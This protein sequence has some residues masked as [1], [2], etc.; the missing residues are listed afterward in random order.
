MHKVG[1]SSYNTLIYIYTYL[2]Y[3]CANIYQRVS[4]LS[5]HYNYVDYFKKYTITWW[6]DCITERLPHAFLL[7][8]AGTA[9]YSN[10]VESKLI[11]GEL[12]TFVCFRSHI[13]HIMVSV[14]L[15]SVN[16]RLIKLTPAWITFSTLFTIEGLGMSLDSIYVFVYLDLY[17][18]CERG[19]I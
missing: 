1:M 7:F 6:M 18:W 11:D 3:T 2:L 4:R 16:S 13:V 9:L 17:L 15:L 12:I 5:M 14:H 8:P 10:V 19:Y